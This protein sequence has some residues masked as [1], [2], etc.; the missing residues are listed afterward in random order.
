MAVKKNK[1]NLLVRQ[2]S[3]YIKAN[4]AT[5]TPPL[6]PLLTPHGIDVK[7]FCNMF[8]NETK[9]L[10]KGLIV[11][12]II[13]VYKNN[14][15]T[16]IIKGT[17]LFFLFELASDEL[18]LKYNYRGYRGILLI[19]LYLITIYKA[20]EYKNM[21]IIELFKMIIQEA[22]KNGYKIIETCDDNNYYLYV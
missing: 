17:P 9:D 8:N 5:T 21:E 3:V 12:V 22:I 14:T 7:Q 1:N 18:E 4:E 20:E 15:F 11:K 10:P 2:V 6:G 16:Y 13:N 19:D